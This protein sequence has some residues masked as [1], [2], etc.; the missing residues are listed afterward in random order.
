[1]RQKGSEEA[2]RH[3]AHALMKCIIRNS[4]LAYAALDALY[5]ELRVGGGFFRGRKMS[6]EVDE[7]TRNEL[8]GYITAL[9]AVLIENSSPGPQETASVV[10][11]LENLVFLPEW[12][13][14]RVAYQRYVVQ[15][16]DIGP[17]DFGALPRHNELL[18]RL[19]HTLIDVWNVSPELLLE[20]G[21]VQ[22]HCEA[23]RLLHDGV[24]ERIL[25]EL[26]KSTNG[27]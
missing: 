25:K 6:P 14:A 15:Y 16:R 9:A 24:E 12:H 3:Q 23:L 2:A 11:A 27:W 4:A 1:M 5:I 17:G 8:V 18:M 19:R 20:D 10:A 26:S 21:I 7:L 22:R 13:A